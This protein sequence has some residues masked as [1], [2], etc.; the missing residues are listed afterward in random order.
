MAVLLS[1]CAGTVAIDLLPGSGLA[2]TNGPAPAPDAAVPASPDE[3]G[4]EGRPET[5]PP[6]DAD[7][8]ESD[9]ADANPAQPGAP[10]P[11]PPAPVPCVDGSV[12]CPPAAPMMVPPGDTE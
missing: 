10:A 12:M 2:V 11:A 5:T 6:A 4:G 7:L 9:D 8:T 1:G 3:P